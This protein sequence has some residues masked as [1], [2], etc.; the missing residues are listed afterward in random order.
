MVGYRSG[1][2][3]QTVNLLANAFDGS[4][5]SP[6]THC[7]VMNLPSAIA[8]VSPKPAAYVV[9]STAGDYLYKG[10]SRNLRERLKDHLAGREPRTKNRRPLALVYYKYFDSYSNAR[11]MEHYLKSGQGRLWL[12]AFLHILPGQT[13]PPEGGPASGVKSVG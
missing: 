2:P 3:G 6:T 5:P 1:Q 11:A 13:V 8:V 12:K 10:S 4:N 9:T 7:P